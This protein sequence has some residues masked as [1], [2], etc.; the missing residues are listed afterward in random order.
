[1]S[2]WM[3]Q[4]QAQR[5]GQFWGCEAG[6]RWYRLTSHGVTVYHSIVVMF[7]AYI[8]ILCQK[9]GGTLAVTSQAPAC[10]SSFHNMPR[11]GMVGCSKAPLCYTLRNPSRSS[12]KVSQLHT[13]CSPAERIHSKETPGKTSCQI[14]F[15]AHALKMLRHHLRKCN[16]SNMAS[17]RSKNE[18]Q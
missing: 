17:N 3:W 5:S 8:I 10:V 2:H 1:M 13:T 7:V 4:Q 14:D 15:T 9:R 16:L 12:K 11:V 6:E 18:E